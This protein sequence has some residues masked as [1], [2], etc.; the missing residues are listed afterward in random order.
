MAEELAVDEAVVGL[1]AVAEQE[2]QPHVLV[3]P[4][5]QQAWPLLVLLVALAALLF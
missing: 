5:D 3:H 1:V 2:R 4:S